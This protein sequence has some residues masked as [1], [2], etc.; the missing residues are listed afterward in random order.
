MERIDF[1]VKHLIANDGNTDKIPKFRY[2]LGDFF[3]DFLSNPG[4]VFKVGGSDVG[5]LLFNIW[6][7]AYLKEF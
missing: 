7:I 3:C 2:S 5:R 1:T 6:Y 4:G